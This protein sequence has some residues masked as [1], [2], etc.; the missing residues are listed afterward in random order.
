MVS[1][2]REQFTAWKSAL[3]TLSPQNFRGAPV[4]W[5]S[6]GRDHQEAPAVELT[7][8]DWRLVENPR[9][10][11]QRTEG[12]RW[13]DWTVGGARKQTF[14]IP[15]VGQMPAEDRHHHPSG[16]DHEPFWQISCKV[17]A[18]WDWLDNLKWDLPSW[19]LGSQYFVQSNSQKPSRA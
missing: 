1:R 12:Q 11:A 18:R 19:L 6:L 3:A 5:S 15:S 10:L 16:R 14:L 8:E 17:S 2:T 13:E 9:A 7:H 4:D